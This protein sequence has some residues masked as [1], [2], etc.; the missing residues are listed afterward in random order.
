[1]EPRY[2]RGAGKHS[3]AGKPAIGSKSSKTN[4]AY[5]F[6]KSASTRTPAAGWRL[7]E[8]AM[9][10]AVVSTLMAAKHLFLGSAW[11]RS[12]PLDDMAMT[13]IFTLGLYHAVILGVLAL[14]ARRQG[15]FMRALS[16][17]ATA[18][19]VRS[20]IGSVVLVIA[21][22]VAT[23][24][25]GWAYQVVA[26]V[27]GWE[28]PA[29]AEVSLI[30]LFGPGIIGWVFIVLLIVILAPITEELV[31]RK[32]LL[33]ALGT[34]LP[35]TAALL[36]QAGIFA[37]FHA[38]PWMWGPMLMLGLACGWLAGQRQTLWPAI[39]LH[40]SYNAVLVAAVFYI[41]Q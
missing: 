8:A 31:F 28:M 18:F 7:R 12:L 36:V 1:L 15:G 10:L 39:F 5:S 17:R 26:R 20:V 9:V 25:A 23:R 33:D 41:H 14:L 27:L 6:R 19:S 24:A 4:A 37:A 11:A 30:Q 13:R 40:M 16:L 34:R 21:L 38:S 2:R 22:L 35:A 29:L 32:V 3:K